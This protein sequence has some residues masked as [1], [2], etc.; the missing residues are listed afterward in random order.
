M[1]NVE[2]VKKLQIV[3]CT[4]CK[5]KTIKNVVRKGPGG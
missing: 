5:H 4:R 3:T 2:R 1:A